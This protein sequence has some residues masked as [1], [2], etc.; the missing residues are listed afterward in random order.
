MKKSIST[1]AL[2]LFFSVFCFGQS[3]TPEVIATAGDYFETE[4]GS[5]SWTLGE[6]IIETVSVDGIG[7]LT[8]GFQ[9]AW[10]YI[11]TIEEPEGLDLEVSIYPNPARD[12]A[13]IEFVS[14][15]ELPEVQLL[16]YDLIG[17]KIMEK[18]VK[19]TH[20]KEQIN[21][22]SFAT[23]MFTLQVTDLKTKK[24]KTFKIMKVKF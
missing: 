6:T 17:N 8:Q 18:T 22:A 4:E 1:L 24:M 11:S 9:Q 2:L 7:T 20:V 19:Q 12:V 13:T 10:F 15:E 14:N 16:M 5:L 23:D 21:L 3:L